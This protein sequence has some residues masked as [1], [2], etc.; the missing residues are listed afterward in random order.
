MLIQ[1]SALR[2]RAA[3]LSGWSI[4]KGHLQKHFKF[5]SFRHSM[6]F[7]GIVANISEKL[8]H[9]PEMLIKYDVVVL[10]VITHDEGGITDKDFRLAEEIEH[11]LANKPLSE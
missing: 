2:E 10:S 11:Y 5:K 7:A 8:N 9:H 1:G 6:S 3:G 4:E